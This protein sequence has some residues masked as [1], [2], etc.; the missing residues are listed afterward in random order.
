MT[1]PAVALIR[2]DGV[3]PEVMAAAEAVLAAAGADIAWREVAAGQEA[4]RQFGTPVP[5]ETVA[6]LKQTR[7]LFKGPLT[8][9]PEYRSPN[10]ALRTY[11]DTYANA[12]LAVCYPPGGRSRYPGL[13]L[14]LI[15]DLTEDIPKGPE[16]VLASG[17]VGVGIK[18]ISRTTSE[19]L[20]RFAGKW[21]RRHGLQR[22]TVGHHGDIQRA[23]DGLFLRC[24][25]EVAA[26]EFPDLT[27]DEEGFDALLMHL[28]IDPSAYQV[29][30]TPNL[31]GG[32]LCGLCSGLAGS[33]GLMGG[34]AFGDNSAL[35]EPAHGSAP[36]HAGSN[37][38]NPT[39]AILAGAMLLDYLGMDA[40]AG[41]VRSAVAATIQANRQVTYDLGGTAG[42]AAMAAAIC[43]RLQ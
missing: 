2:G 25:Q 10:S 16:Q 23:T 4:F 22:I 39:A 42:T 3:G 30:L 34:G 20:A 26:A 1:A 7:V 31:Y 41:R 36:K 37:R 15:R 19:R 5:P 6:V 33:V 40:V 43:S 28:A 21:A 24:V 8:T 14:T 27:V 12:R 9:P 17:Q 29:L 11:L 32:F 13:N 38:V 35:F 18:V